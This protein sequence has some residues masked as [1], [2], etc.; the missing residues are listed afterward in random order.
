MSDDAARRPESRPSYWPSAASGI[1]RID[2]TSDRSSSKLSVRPPLTRP[3]YPPS[4][5][6]TAAA[7]SRGRAACCRSS[8][9]PPGP[10]GCPP[11]RRPTSSSARPTG[12]SR[13]SGRASSS[14]PPEAR[15]EALG[16][17]VYRVRHAELAAH[18][19]PRGRR[20]VARHASAGGARA[21]PGGRRPWRAFPRPRPPG[22]RPYASSVGRPRSATSQSSS[23]RSPPAGH[24][25]LGVRY[26]A[27]A[28]G[29]ARDASRRTWGTRPTPRPPCRARRAPACAAAL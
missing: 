28:N 24:A 23:P 26:A 4:R 29:A 21:Y 7:P 18:G 19:L 14:R 20:V 11:C 25:H 27:L 8:P 9:S 22:P 1:R 5:T 2:G 12:T 17:R 13:G 10:T 15:Q 3:A 6:R 16:P